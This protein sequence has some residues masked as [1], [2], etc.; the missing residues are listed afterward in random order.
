MNKMVIIIVAVVVVIG[1]VVGLGVAGIVPIPGLTHTKTKKSKAAEAAAAQA[2]KD[3]ADKEAADKAKAVAESIKKATGQRDDLVKAGKWSE[4]LPLAQQTYDLLNKN[5]P[6]SP[7]VAAASQVLSN[8]KDEVAK[9][10][11]PKPDPEK[12]YTKLASVWG[13]LEPEKIKELLEA[14]YKPDTAAPILKKMDDDKVA[15]IL[16]AMTPDKRAAY[17]EALAAEASK[18]VT[19]KTS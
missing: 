19:P 9:A 1:A 6:G 4:A 13:E 14:S 2:E 18:P 15:A 11:A 10:N 7:D 16:A 5:K 17:S 3:A 12:G 8:V